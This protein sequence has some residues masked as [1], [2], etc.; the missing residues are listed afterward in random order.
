MS[1][2]VVADPA[3]RGRAQ[4]ILRLD[5]ADVGMLSVLDEVRDRFDPAAALAEGVRAGSREN[6]PRVISRGALLVPIVPLDGDPTDFGVDTTEEFSMVVSDRR[7]HHLWLDG[8]FHGPVDL[9]A[10]WNPG[11]QL[12]MGPLSN[13]ES[14][15]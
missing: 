8:A 10:E 14:D 3:G 13:G 12:V 9:P 1:W 11:D 7:D 4:W 5:G 2:E 6:V 15:V